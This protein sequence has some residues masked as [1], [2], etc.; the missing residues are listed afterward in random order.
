MDDFCITADALSLGPL[1]HISDFATAAT[2]RMNA[3]IEARI[4]CFREC[5]VELHRM[6]IVTERFNGRTSL[7]VD[8]IARFSWVISYGH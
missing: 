2:E 5:G 3:E 7:C 6:S 8:N 1:A 4:E